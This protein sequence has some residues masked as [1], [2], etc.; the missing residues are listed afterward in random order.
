MGGNHDGRAEPP[1]A[2]GPAADGGVEAAAATFGLVTN[3]TRVG[4]LR[5]LA[6]H[7]R[8]NPDDPALPFA[9]LRERVEGRVER[10]SEN[11]F[12]L[13][14]TVAADGDRLVAVL[15]DRGQTVDVSHPDG[16]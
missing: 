6:H 11:P 2:D 3:D 7:Q 14:V 4:V 12:R 1:T 15:D 16:G 5:E 8:D 10:R 9:E 13:A